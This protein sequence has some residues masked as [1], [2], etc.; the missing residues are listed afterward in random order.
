MKALRPATQF[1]RDLRR[2]AKRGKS[3]D[4]LEA[5]LATLA[6]GEPL[7]A[8]HRVHRLRGDHEGLWECHIEPDWLLIWE[9]TDDAIHLA[10]CGSHADLSE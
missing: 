2:A 4:K 1:R 3:L 10:R 7:A 6:R 5:V 9:E 8:R